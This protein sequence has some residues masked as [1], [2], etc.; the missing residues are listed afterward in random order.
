MLLLAGG[1]DLIA[2]LKDRGIRVFLDLKWHDIPHAVAGA[3][4]GAARL[5]VDL[6]T[7][8][9]L[10]GEEMVRAAVRARGTTRVAGVTV[11][12]SHTEASLAAALG[13]S[14]VD[15]EAEVARLA[16]MLVSVGVDAIVASPE[17]IATV[18]AVAGPAIWIVVPGIRPLGTESGD[19]RRVATPAAAAA[20]GASHLVVGRPIL[21]AKNPGQVYQAICEAIA[22]I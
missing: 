19:Q 9:A 7:V 10:G 11:L 2:E 4:A 14:E 3:V 15:L 1:L 13:R 6:V 21:E 16:G 18:R 20:A 22:G 17:E 8:H 12:T 5:G